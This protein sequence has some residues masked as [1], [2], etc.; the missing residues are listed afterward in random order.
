MINSIS[1][2]LNLI[3]K[4][5]PSSSIPVSI[6]NKINNYLQNPLQFQNKCRLIFP[7]M[8]EDIYAGRICRHQSPYNNTNNAYTYVETGKHSLENGLDNYAT[9]KEEW[10][11]YSLDDRLNIFLKAADL[12]ENDYY[13]D[14]L[15]TTIMGQNKNIYEAEIDAICELVDFIRFNVDYMKQI[16]ERQPISLEDVKNESIYNPLNGFVAAITPFNFTAIG[17]NLASLPLMMGNVVF[18][19]PSDN[20]LLSN[21]LFYNILIEAGLPKGVLNFVPMDPEVFL[22]TIIKRPDLGGILFTGSSHVFDN[23]YRSVGN[24][25]HIYD[26]Y[27][28]LVGETGGKNFHFIDED[29]D[30]IL[31]YVIDKTF[32]SAYNYSGQKCSSCSRVYLPR[33][34]WEDF[35]LGMIERIKN[36]KGNYG[37]INNDAYNRIN[38]IIN[39]IMDN[40]N[41]TLE[42]GGNNNSD[43]SYYIE[44]CIVLCKDPNEFV[45]NEEFF[46]PICA[47]YLYDDI[48]KAMEICKTASKYALTGAIFSDNEEWIKKGKQY[49]RYSVGNLYVNDKST[50][51]VVG[52]QPF[53]GSGKS[54]TNDKAGD[55]NML[56]RMINQMNIKNQIIN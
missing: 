4:F 54:G 45:F 20:A 31:P 22:N 36:M 51:A 37:V 16:T 28:R 13:E 25:I 10:N 48:D 24:N 47:V 50:G 29:V 56:Y 43:G 15:A 14:M 49:F 55:I 40:P 39:K 7:S 27:P 8:K 34:L 52:Q 19:K 46:A 6:Q 53:G 21:K 5:K 44:P 33:R 32:E 35:R 23:I 17:C 42:Y 41:M 26:N 18:W 1:R 2:C 9:I 38:N 3:P 11:N 30:D 12:I